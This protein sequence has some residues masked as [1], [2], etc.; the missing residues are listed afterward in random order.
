MIQIGYFLDVYLFDNEKE[1]INSDFIDMVEEL[2]ATSPEFNENV[3]K[4]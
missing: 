2:S 4:G 1:N 3:N